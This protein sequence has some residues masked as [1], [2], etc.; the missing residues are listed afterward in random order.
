MSSR[1]YKSQTH[2]RGERE[3]A[4]GRFSGYSRF[5]ISMKNS[6]EMRYNALFRD[7]PFFYCDAALLYPFIG[8][9]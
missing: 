5:E 1:P 6:K 4:L 3:R 8:V 9:R 2:R 7:A